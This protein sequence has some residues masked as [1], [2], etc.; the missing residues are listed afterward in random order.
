MPAILK[1]CRLLTGYLEA[2]ITKK[3]GYQGTGSDVTNGLSA[4]EKNGVQNENPVYVE[5]FTPKDPDQRGA[6]LS[7]SF[8]ISI[9]QV[10]EEL[11]K[12]G[13]IVSTLE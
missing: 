6:Q 11:M 9:I 1:K 10:F 7:L 12:R 4:A 8:S 3:Y 13:V 5:I 2:R